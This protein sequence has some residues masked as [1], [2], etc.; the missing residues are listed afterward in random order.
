VAA[1]DTIGYPVALKAASPDLVHKTERGGVVTDLDSAAA[2]QAAFLDMHQRLGTDMGG[3]IVQQMLGSGVETIVGVVRDRHFGPLLVFG[4]GGTAVGLMGDQAFRAAPLT[5]VDVSELIHEPRGSA[6]LFGY[7]GSLPCD[8]DALTGIIQR[9]SAL[10]TAVPEIAEM[11]LNPVICSP[12]GAVAVDV[13]IR[14]E[15]T[16]RD[17]LA[18]ARRLRRP[19]PH[20]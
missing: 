19:S 13:K 20:D 7:R 12:T 15:P 11:D 8:T 5:D 3:A 16:P 14:L 4:S 6:L 1:A 17:P 2:V 18:A 10:V 9:I